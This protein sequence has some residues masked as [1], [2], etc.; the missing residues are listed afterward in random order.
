MRSHVIIFFS[1]PYKYFQ[2]S[3]VTEHKTDQDFLR[4]LFVSVVLV[5]DL[6][7]KVDLAFR[8]GSSKAYA[9]ADLTQREYSYKTIHIKV[10]YT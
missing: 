6:L 9:L 4:I 2:T 8:G 7:L 1:S 10:I 5:N 3:F